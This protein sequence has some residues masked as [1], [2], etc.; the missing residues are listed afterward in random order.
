MQGRWIWLMVALVAAAALAAFACRPPRV[1]AA[2]APATAFSAERAMADVRAI[3]RA[4]HVTGSL[5]SRR[6]RAHLAA[7]LRGMGLAVSEQPVPLTDKGLERLSSWA[8]APVAAVTGANVIGVLAGRDRAQP[9][10]L[11]MAH[12]DSVWRSPGAADDAMGVA[13]VLETVRAIRAG[14]R[15]ARD[16]IV[17]LTDGEELGLQGAHAFFERHPLSRHVGV[18]INSETRGAAGRAV[19]FETGPGNGGMMRLFGRVAPTPSAASVA[20]SIY[21]TMP[22]STDLTVALKHVPAGFNFAMQDRAGLYHSPLA[23]PERIEPASVQD[24]GGQVLAIA[25]ALAFA[26]ALPGPETDVAFQDVLGT[27]LIL[28]PLWVGWLILGGAAGLLALAVRRAALGWG[29]VAQGMVP[30][31]AVLPLGGLLLMTVNLVSGSGP[32]HN[33]Y[34]RLAALPLL[35]VQA[36]LLVAATVLAAAGLLPTQRRWWALVPVAAMGIVALALGGWVPEVV[37]FV[38]FGALAAFFCPVVE[39]RAGWL[40]AILLGLALAAVVQAVLPAAAPVLAWPVLIA[41]LAAFGATWLDPA[42]ERRLALAKV[43]AAGAIGCGSSFAYAHLTMISIGGPHA[44]VMALFGLIAL[45][46]LRPLI[47]PVRWPWVAALTAAA[48]AVALWVRLD[49]V[50]PSTATY[51]LMMRDKS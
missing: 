33:Y 11:L 12:H 3:G 15:P 36:W 16:V 41:A 18:V 40:G 30:A 47:G 34:D 35:E 44:G 22:N 14:G 25:R 29:A 20:V 24:M 17:L 26:P 45:M 19:M 9:A 6:V 1:V 32:G 38:S 2:S 7:R 46:L 8:Q 4:P 23:T 43:A 28:Y 37:T 10:V 39:R 49:P 5:E 42:V 48:L 50:A 21:R 27:A 13:T 51:S 31:V